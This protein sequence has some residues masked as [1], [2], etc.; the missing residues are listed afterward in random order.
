MWCIKMKN[1]LCETTKWSGKVHCELYIGYHKAYKCCYESY[2]SPYML[3]IG[4]RGHY[5]GTMSLETLIW[6][7]YAPLGSS[8]GIQGSI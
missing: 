3:L 2:I 5:I 7:T 1:E 8:H 4:H 6:S